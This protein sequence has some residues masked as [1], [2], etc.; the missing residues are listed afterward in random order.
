[1][2]ARDGGRDGSKPLLAIALIWKTCRTN[3][4]QIIIGNRPKISGMKCDQC[5]RPTGGGHEFDPDRLGAIDLHH[6][7]Q[8]APPQPVSRYVMGQH[9]DIERMNGHLAPPG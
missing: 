9:D 3:R 1:M 2:I 8:I 5:L 7:T 4:Y 6:R